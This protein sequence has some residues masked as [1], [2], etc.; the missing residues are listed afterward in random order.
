MAERKEYTPPTF[1]HL[2]LRDLDIVYESGIREEAFE[3]APGSRFWSKETLGHWIKNQENDVLLGAE[4]DGRL[5]GYALAKIHHPTGE[6]ALDNLYVLEEFRER[7][8]A[9]DLLKECAR[10]LR[11]KGAKYLGAITKPHNETVMR[12]FQRAGG[13]IGHT[14]VWLDMD[15]E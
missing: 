10:R 5:A 15:L 14:F 13:Q 3:V 2:E 4:V 9:K 7:G 1:R 6:A 8:V 12:I 11:E